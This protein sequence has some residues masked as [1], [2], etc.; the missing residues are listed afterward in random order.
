MQ[1]P[2]LQKLDGVV[3]EAVAPFGGDL[4]ESDEEDIPL[5]LK[6][7]EASPGLTM[8]QS[9]SQRNLTIKR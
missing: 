2:L 3:T 6:F 7:M 4:L 5:P 1:G 9:L 8:H